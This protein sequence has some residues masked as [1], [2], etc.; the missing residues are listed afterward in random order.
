M[1]FSR[2]DIEPR[3][4]L[5]L[6]LVL[7]V[8]SLFTVRS[9]QAQYRV[10]HSLSS[11]NLGEYGRFGGAVASVGD[12]GGNDLPDVIVGAAPEAVDGID[13]AGRAYVVDGATGDVLYSLRSPNPDSAGLFGSSV[14]GIGDVD[15]D[16][17]PDIL[18]GAEGET[19]E[20]V[21]V[22]GRVYLFSGGDGSHIRTFTPN[23]PK[24]YSR[25]GGSLDGLPDLTDSGT[26]EV[27]VG[28]FIETVSSTAGA[29]RVYLI[30]AANGAVVDS[31]ESL[32]PEEYGLFGESV[33]GVGDVTNDDS[34]D[35]LVGAPGETHPDS[36]EGRAYV[37]TGATLTHQQTL[38]SK[39]S[40]TTGNF[41]RAVAGVG[42]VS[43]DGTADVAV[44]APG[45]SV[46]ADSAGRAYIFD[47]VNDTYLT[48]MTSPTPTVS[49]AF[50]SAL[51]GVGDVDG[52][53]GLLVGA[54][55]DEVDGVS[56]GRAYLLRGTD[57]SVFETLSSSDPEY[58]GDFGIAVAEVADGSGDRSSDL[59]VGANKETVDDDV[60]AGRAYT[61]TDP[62]TP[63]SGLTVNRDSLDI[64]IGWD[65]V[66]A[67]DIAEYRVYRDTSQ[68]DST[69]GPEDYTAIG[70]TSGTTSYVDT[71]TVPE[72]TQYYRV[73][74][75]NG[76]G[77]ESSF[78]ASADLFLYPDEIVADVTQSFG[79]ANEPGDY[80]LVALPGDVNRALAETINGEAGLDWQAY[81][82]DG[83]SSS[84]LQKADES[85]TFDFRPGRGFWVT[86]TTSWT[87][88][89]TVPTVS[90]QGDTATAIPVHDG[91]NI[92]SNP[93]GRDVS[94]TAVERATGT[95]LKPLWE[96]GNTF[97]QTPTFGS[98]GK[99]TA[100][101][102]RNDQG[103]DSL[104]IPHPGVSQTKK[105]TGA[106]RTTT[107]L[108][109]R[110]HPTGERGTS[111]IVRIRFADPEVS[112]EG[113]GKIV[114]PPGQFSAVSLRIEPED[115]N[116]RG[117]LAE[118]RR[119]TSE[120][121]HTFDLQLQNRTSRQ[122]RIDAQGL[123]TV[124]HGDVA[125]L[126]PGSGRS[127]DLR[128]EGG[129]V[130]S[131]SRQDSVGLTLAVGTER[132]VEAE[133]E[134]LLP[135]EVSLSA[136]PNPVRE[137][138]TISYSLPEKKQVELVLYDVLG[139]RVEVLAEGRK[140]PGRHRVEV[141]TKS[142]ASG[143][144]FGRL[145][146]GQERRV[147]KITVLK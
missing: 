30:S 50:G 42:D 76:A 127:Y 19:V 53:P 67:D 74:A 59:L 34:T 132:Y 5:I 46:E 45:E 35:V 121:G 112:R 9:S 124:P 60:Q 15:G 106:T 77:V 144:Y 66:D 146:V 17:V 52:G 88:E 117:R 37:F 38:E 147:Q 70:S 108:T 8:G 40:T 84:F 81:W 91:W 118:V 23:T 86:S 16:S 33:A 125:L 73:T 126:R 13:Q 85:D 25:F 14:A 111:S 95:D 93:F 56:T 1:V 135:V 119:P 64:D 101:Y 12:V 49:G 83:T 140:R 115:W 96:F 68:I 29:G 80:E 22:V 43:G 141:P 55:G 41:G 63:P 7:A 105:K 21:K 107:P 75:V 94:W 78:S 69:A 138:A 114:A 31:T 116:R 61:F 57:G 97:V 99:G 137:Q 123:E 139:R 72:A 11:P 28:A 103:L 128:E 79:G 104:L 54:P 62:P 51:D 44:G 39:N 89:T 92:V 65:K 142:L 24:R 109:V 36:S 32:N 10:W 71:S 4:G 102:F 82:D 120:T 27:L 47:V 113:S 18:V 58:R 133:Q 98:A 2:P 3:V 110:A 100:Y 6:V 129:V 130:L 90:L 20:G 131:E 136:Y 122:I 145:R 134:R 87:V 26:P 48:S 143:V